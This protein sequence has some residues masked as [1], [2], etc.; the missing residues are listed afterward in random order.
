[1]EPQTNVRRTGMA[2]G[3]CLGDPCSNPLCSIAL[4]FLLELKH[5]VPLYK[6]RNTLHGNTNNAVT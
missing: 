1:M 6:T 5:G 3:S 2:L 4:L